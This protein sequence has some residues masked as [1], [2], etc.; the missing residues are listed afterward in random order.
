MDKDVLNDY[1]RFRSLKGIEQ[2]KLSY[3]NKNKRPS[4]REFVKLENSPMYAFY[5]YIS[6]M[7]QILFF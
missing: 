4:V 3:A 6:M 7:I 5:I 1:E 2:K